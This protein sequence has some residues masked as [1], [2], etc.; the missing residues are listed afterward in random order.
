MHRVQWIILTVI[1]HLTTLLAAQTAFS[2]EANTYRIAVL[3]LQP[4]GVS[5]IE[6]R[7]LSEKLRSS[8]SQLIETGDSKDKYTLVERS[9][10]AK[11]FEQFDI[12]NTGCTDISCAVEFGKMLSAE[13]IVIGQ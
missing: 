1:V 7:A 3:D 2:Q 4:I 9:Q 5:Q 11:T 13:R 6:A 12:Q 8:V 10:M